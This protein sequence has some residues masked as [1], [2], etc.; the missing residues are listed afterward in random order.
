MSDIKWVMPEHLEPFR[1]Y[2]NNVSGE[3]IEELMNDKT[4]TLFN[5]SIRGA[6][7]VACQS[8]LKLLQSLYDAALLTH[9]K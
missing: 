3:S 9:P 6:L 8:Q 1:K 7:I 2:I 5:T 4:T